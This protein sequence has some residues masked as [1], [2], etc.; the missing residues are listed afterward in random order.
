MIDG[1]TNA[2]A[3]PVLERLMQ[4]ASLRH[5]FIAENAANLTTP[6][7]RPRDL[8]VEGFQAALRDAVDARRA[9]RGGRAAGTLRPADTDELTFHDGGIEARPSVLG[10]NILFHDGND[11]DTEKTMQMLAENLIT[12]RLGVEMF[13]RNFDL[14][15]TAIRERL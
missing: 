1:V 8:S 7:Y 4:F 12:L 11:R 15:N 5:G 6:N 2:G 13:R 3:V 9:E 14:M 10:Q